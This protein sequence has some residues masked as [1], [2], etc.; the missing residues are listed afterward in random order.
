MTILVIP[1]KGEQEKS[2]EKRSDG[3]RTNNSMMN[4]SNSDSEEQ[5]SIENFQK[6]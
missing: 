5:N 4:K 3:D 1:F 6:F 2:L